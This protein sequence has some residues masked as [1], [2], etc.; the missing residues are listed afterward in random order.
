MRRSGH[1]IIQLFGH[2]GQCIAINRLIFMPEP[3]SLAWLIHA[4]DYKTA[5]SYTEFTNTSSVCPHCQQATESAE[6]TLV[7]CQE[8]YTFWSRLYQ[9][10][11]FS[12]YSRPDTR[13]ILPLYIA[14]DCLLALACGLWVIHYTRLCC[15][16]SQTCSLSALMFL[17]ETDGEREREKLS[18]YYKLPCMVARFN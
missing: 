1:F 10:F 12:Q 3:C 5:K 16:F 11:R 13:S 15:H 14:K 8:V 18:F 6:H 7:E 2:A 9:M 4:G 17:I